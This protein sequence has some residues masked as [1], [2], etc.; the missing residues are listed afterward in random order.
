MSKDP[1]TNEASKRICK[2][3][4]EDHDD[5]IKSYAS[6]YGGIKNPVKAKMIEITSQKMVL[7]VDGSLISID[8]DHILANSED[9]HQ[10]LIS[11]LRSIP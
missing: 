9:A 4:N 8:F 1:L 2:H 3:M 10:T 6:Y 11:M 5:A 7:N